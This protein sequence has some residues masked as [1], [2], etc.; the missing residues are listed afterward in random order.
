M[1]ETPTGGTDAPEATDKPGE[2]ARPED[3]TTAE[4]KAGP[5]GAGANAAP[6]PPLPPPPRPYYDR[7]LKKHDWM[8]FALIA[9]SVIAVLLLASTISLAVMRCDNN[10]R[11]GNQERIFGNPDFRGN[12]GMPRFRMNPRNQGEQD[13]PLA[14]QTTPSAPQQ[15]PAPPPSP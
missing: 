8:L 7:P 13:Q 3:A 4:I 14:P 12:Q 9:V 10:C 1:D 11:F 5:E 15:A 6:P 2:E